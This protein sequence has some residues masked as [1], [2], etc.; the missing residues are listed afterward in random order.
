[1]HRKPRFA[2]H[3]LYILQSLAKR[4]DI[5]KCVIN[6]KADPRR[7]AVRRSE[8]FMRECGAVIA[9]SYAYSVLVQKRTE[10]ICG[11]SARAEKQNRSFR[12]GGIYVYAVEL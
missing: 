4:V 12:I 3:H 2:V 8:G 6:S 10:L 1:M 11:Y 5:I 9:R 7:T